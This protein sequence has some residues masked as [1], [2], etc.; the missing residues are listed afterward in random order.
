MPTIKIAAIQASADPYGENRVFHPLPMMNAK[1]T[2]IPISAINAGLSP[3]L[4]LLFINYALSS[5]ELNS[6][7]IVSL[8]IRLLCDLML[9]D[10]IKKSQQ[11]ASHA[12]SLDL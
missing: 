9:T 11:A 4:D 3:E 8:R 6:E 5:L 12:A 10:C 2:E 7:W 1:T